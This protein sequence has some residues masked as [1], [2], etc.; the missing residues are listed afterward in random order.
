M[1]RGRWTWLAIGLIAAGLLRFEWVYADDPTGRSHLL[2]SRV[3]LSWHDYDAS[4]LADREAQ[5]VRVRLT[6][7]AWLGLYRWD[8]TLWW[9]GRSPLVHDATASSPIG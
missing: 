1:R 5:I 6:R 2:M 8:I 9:P 4:A 7:W 3:G